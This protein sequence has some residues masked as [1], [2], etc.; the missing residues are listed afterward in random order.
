[1]DLRNTNSTD[2]RYR[3]PLNENSD[4]DTYDAYNLKLSM[5]F[6]G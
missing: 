2:D 5:S 6:Y 1:M 3:F 4:R